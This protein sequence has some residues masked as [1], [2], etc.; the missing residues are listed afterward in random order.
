MLVHTQREAEIEAARST[1]ARRIADCIT[2]MN[3]EFYKAW[4][5]VQSFKQNWLRNHTIDL[6]FRHSLKNVNEQYKELISLTDDQRALQSHIYL[7]MR[8]LEEG[9]QIIA[10]A[11]SDIEAGKV[12]EVLQTHAKKMARLKQ[13]FRSCMSHEIVIFAEHEKAVADSS[14]G[15]QAALR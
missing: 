12:E 4:E 9:E 7:S 15:R 8:Q 1:K 13:M 3:N 2:R 14:N 10:Q 6:S 11:A 5:A